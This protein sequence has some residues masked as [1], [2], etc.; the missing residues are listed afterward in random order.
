LFRRKYAKLR[1][2]TLDEEMPAGRF[3]HMGKRLNTVRDRLYTKLGREPTHEEWATAC[4]LG[5]S[6][7]HNYLDVSRKSQNRLVSHNIRLVDF[8]VRKLMEYSLAAKEI[9][10]FDLV[11]E[12]LVGLRKA[13]ESFDGSGSS[14]PTVL[15]TYPLSGAPHPLHALWTHGRLL[16]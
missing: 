3:S 4:R 15:I 9:S 5:I 6:D 10:Y 1:F 12:G 14:R 7:L 13:A 11:V 2:L 16:P 8:W